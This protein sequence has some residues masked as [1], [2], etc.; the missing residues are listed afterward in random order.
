MKCGN[1]MTICGLL[2]IAVALILTAFNLQRNETAK[3][4]T[5]AAATQILTEI[6]LR[7]TQGALSAEEKAALS[8]T[9]QPEE[10]AYRNNP[11]IEMPVVTID[12]EDYIGLLSLPTLDLQ[13]P[14][15]SQWNDSRLRTAPC[16]F[17]GSVYQDNLVIAAHNYAAHFGK[18]SQLHPGDDLQF[19]DTDGNVFSFE[20]VELE[21]LRPTQVEDMTQS[22]YDLTLFTCTVGGQSRIAVRCRRLPNEE[23]PCLSA[24]DFKIVLI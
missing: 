22:G 1:W 8:E 4:V 10:P 20:V 7:Q 9:V 6:T 3:R 19:T 23:V 14:V 5:Q 15:I 16:R 21:T 18:L 2:L 12:G 24:W 13:L 17:F 11:Q